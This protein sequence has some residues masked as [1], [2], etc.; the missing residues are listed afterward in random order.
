ML[1]SIDTGTKKDVE[2]IDEI[3]L[4]LIDFS[5]KHILEE[6]INNEISYE[7]FK[8]LFQLYGKEKVNMNEIGENICISNSACTILIDK[9]I[10]LELVERKRSD[11]DRRLVE[12]YITP[13]GKESLSNI[14]K[15]RHELVEDFLSS[16]TEQEQKIISQ[17]IL[18]LSKNIQYF[19]DKR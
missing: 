19:K 15:K 6:S 11:K 8:V 16:M 10:K 13:K 5:K 12:V 1:S 9:L 3:F 4:H 18:I 17:S 2:I 14:I 7:Q